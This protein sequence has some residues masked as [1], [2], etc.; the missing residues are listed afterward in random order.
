MEE[1]TVRIV[2]TGGQ[3]FIGKAVVENLL[4]RGHEVV[5]FD[6]VQRPGLPE[7][8]TF[9][10]GDVRDAAAVE[11][12]I[13]HSDGFIHLAAILGT[14]E[15]VISPKESVDTNIHGA[16]NVFRAARLHNR[17]GV[18]IATGSSSWNNTYAITK[19]CAERFAYMFNAEFDTRI[20]VVEAV[21]VYG[22]YQK[23]RPVRKAVPSFISRALLGDPIQIYGDG[24][25]ILDMLY[26]EDCAEIL[27][28]ALLMDHGVY[29]SRLEAG[30]GENITCN[31]LARMIVELTGTDSE[32]E[33][34]PMRPGEPKRSHT[35]GN[36][37]TL[38]PLGWGAGDFTPLHEGL[39]RTIRWYEENAA[40]L[41]L[42]EMAWG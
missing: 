34:L 9:E 4:A 8:A 10:L 38:A 6:R 20:A 36:P 26:I 25:Q 19:H 32:I 18:Q 27:V 41:G 42:H 29:Q 14:A 31:Q 1:A 28:R 24:E 35:Q 22:P 17:R 7:G 3:G 11:E 21:N 33:Y 39:E 37:A 12:T 13:S 5:V 15:T 16:L 40:S 30:T 23:I 2:V